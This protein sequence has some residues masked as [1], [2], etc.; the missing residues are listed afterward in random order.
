MGHLP[1]QKSRSRRTS[2]ANRNKEGVGY[3]IKVLEFIIASCVFRKVLEKTK[4]LVCIIV[5]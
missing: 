4:R 1:Y 3:L 5:N 2:L